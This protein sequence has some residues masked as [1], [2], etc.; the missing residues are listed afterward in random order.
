MS[1]QAVNVSPFPQPPEYARNY[2][3]ANI[4]NKAVLPPPNIPNQYTVFGE[5]YDIHEV[6][7]LF[8]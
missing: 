1:A 8:F 3:D 4:K 5:D 7:T 6:C 2:T